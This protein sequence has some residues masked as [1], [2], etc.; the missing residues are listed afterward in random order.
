MI[1]HYLA[2]IKF[3]M[4]ADQVETIPIQATT[5]HKAKIFAKNKALIRAKEKETNVVSIVSV[6]EIG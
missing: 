5:L 1:K 3:N 2:T 4:S 6:K